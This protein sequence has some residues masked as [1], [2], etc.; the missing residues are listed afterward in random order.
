MTTFTSDFLEFR[1]EFNKRAQE[2]GCSKIPLMPG[3]QNMYRRARALVE[4]YGEAWPTMDEIDAGLKG[5]ATFGFHMRRP[6]WLL[7]HTSRDADS[8]PNILTC[9]G[10]ADKSKPV[11]E[12]PNFPLGKRGD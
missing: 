9:V 8:Y 3:I 11:D 1:T 10:H 7:A 5:M 4:Q 6:G 12:T 2:W